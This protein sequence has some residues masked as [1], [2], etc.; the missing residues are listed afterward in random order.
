VMLGHQVL[1]RAE[2][3]AEHVCKLARVNR[4]LLSLEHARL[5]AFELLISFNILLVLYP[6]R[7]NF[8]FVFFI[9]DILR[10]EVLPLVVHLVSNQSIGFF[11]RLSDLVIGCLLYVH[12]HLYE[13][14]K[15][16]GLSLKNLD[17]G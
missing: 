10:G 5:G 11:E 13:L 17:F 15:Q 3:H 7:C 6:Q 2:G 12:L 16:L 14:P 4:N 8:T 9:F 1:Q